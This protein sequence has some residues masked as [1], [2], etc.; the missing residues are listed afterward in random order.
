MYRLTTV[1]LGLVA[2]VAMT[3]SPDLSPS[4]VNGM[5]VSGSDQ[6][7]RMTALVSLSDFGLR[8]VVKVEKGS[9]K[10]RIEGSC[11]KRMSMP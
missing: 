8:I 7:A 6:C 2:N 1:T 3:K 9:S 4:N 5:S 11:R 10:Q